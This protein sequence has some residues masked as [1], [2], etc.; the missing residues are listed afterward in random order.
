MEPTGQSGQ[1][2]APQPRRQG[3]AGDVVLAYLHQQVSQLTQLEPQVR[4]GDP[5]ALH[6]MR[7][8][9]RR[10][11]SSLATYRKLLDALAANQLRA[12][13]KW[14]A[15]VLGAARD[16]EVMRDRLHRLVSQQPAELIM[17]PVDQRID[18]ELESHFTAAHAAEAAQPI[19][20][21]RA[22]RLIAAAHKIQQLLG[23]HQDSVVTRDL[24]QRLGINAHVAGENSF[25]FGR[26][27]GLEQAAAA[28]FEAKFRR[29][30]E[31]S[32][33]E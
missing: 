16:A 14:L 25:T 21:K 15:G 19:M 8:A 3:A 1:L 26:L 30:W 22:A 33:R 18:L 5:V 7:V 11:R 27:H 28:H 2:R 29:A 12:E 23:E 24:L 13:L 20:G 6:Q 10:M 31:R 32:S 17:G 4:L 9:T